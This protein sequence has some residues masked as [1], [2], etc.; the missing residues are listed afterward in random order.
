MGHIVFGANYD[1]VGFGVSVMLSCVLITPKLEGI[2]EPD[3]H[4]YNVG[5]C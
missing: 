2:L 4:G 1:G 5:E 3:L